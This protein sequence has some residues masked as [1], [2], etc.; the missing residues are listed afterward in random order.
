[1]NQGTMAVHAFLFIARPRIDDGSVSQHGAALIRDVKQVAVALHA[2][3]VLKR[4]IGRFTI[5]F[6]I[7]FALH[8]VNEYVFNAVQRLLIE[9]IKWQSMQSATKPWALL[10]WVEVFQVL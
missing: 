3:F 7:V 1:M 8:E 2:L 5:F 6:A 9:K 4:S 10:T